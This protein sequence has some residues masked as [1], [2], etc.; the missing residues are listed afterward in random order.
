MENI[1]NEPT[2]VTDTSQ[3]L[4][5][6][7]AITDNITTY[8]SGII[9]IPPDISDHHGTYVYMHYDIMAAVPFKRKV[10]NY[11]RAGF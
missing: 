4:I 11:K 3:T 5:D 1:I 10:W 9:Q 7:I 6:P 8:D 2:R